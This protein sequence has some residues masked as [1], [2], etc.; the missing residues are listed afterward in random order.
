[1][2]EIV[3]CLFVT[4]RRIAGFVEDF[5]RP[6][7]LPLVGSSL[8]RGRNVVFKGVSRYSAS[9]T[10]RKG[11]MHG[12]RGLRTGDSIVD[13]WSSLRNLYIV[14][15]IALGSH[16][17]SAFGAPHVCSSEQSWR[18]HRVQLPFEVKS[19]R[20]EQKSRRASVLVNV[21]LRR[22]VNNPSRP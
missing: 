2:C 6:E 14:S 8:M 20:V 15:V 1:M 5:I 16:R 10:V 19:E 4:G 17:E 21:F 22:A 12:Q 7:R 11:C 18:V 13:R 9:I 3:I